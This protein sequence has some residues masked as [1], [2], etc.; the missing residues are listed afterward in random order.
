MVFLERKTLSKAI[1][2]RL[3]STKITARV[4][5]IER[6]ISNSDSQ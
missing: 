5:P 4:I 6:Q 1:K 3:N 2:N